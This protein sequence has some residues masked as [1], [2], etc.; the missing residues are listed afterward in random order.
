MRIKRLT[1]GAYHQDST[2]HAFSVYHS[3]SPAPGGVAPDVNF[4]RLQ[5]LDAMF[6]RKDPGYIQSTGKISATF[7]SSPAHIIRDHATGDVYISAA[8]L[9]D[10]A[11]RLGNYLLAEVSSLTR[12]QVKTGVANDM[13]K[14]LDGFQSKQ[15][16][17]EGEQELTT[18]EEAARRNGGE[19]RRRRDNSRSP[20]AEPMDTDV[21]PPQRHDSGESYRSGRSEAGQRS[22]APSASPALSRQRESSSERLELRPHSDVGPGQ[23]P[24]KPALRLQDSNESLHRGST[25]IDTAPVKRNRSD[26]ELSESAQS[27]ATSEALNDDPQGA[28]RPRQ[29]K[30]L[31]INTAVGH[32][33]PGR[34][35]SSALSANP[36]VLEQVRSSLLLKQ[37][38][39][40]IIEARQ[41][42]Q[43]QRNGPMS[44]NP[45][46]SMRPPM[47]AGGPN[48][49][50]FDQRG[51]RRQ[52]SPK[53]KKGKLSVWT[54]EGTSGAG[55]GPN[56]PSVL[57]P[58]AGRSHGSP[59]SSS[60]LSPRHLNPQPG[61][62]T[63]LSA[64]GAGAPTGAEAS[65]YN[66]VS[67]M[68]PRGGEFPSR[69]LPLPTPMHPHHGS[70]AQD[71]DGPP[72]SPLPH[73][74][75]SQKHFS[76]SSL[77]PPPSP[78]SGFPQ[79]SGHPGSNNPPH[80]ALPQSLAISKSAFVSVAE[81]MY[82]QVE[83]TARLQYT[84][85]DQI[86]RSTAM[87]QTL[88]SSGQ[89]IEGLVRGHFREMQVAYGEKFGSALYEL[90]RRV[91]RLERGTAANSR[92]GTVENGYDNDDE[93]GNNK[94]AHRRQ[95]SSSHLLETG[96][97]DHHHHSSSS[98]RHATPAVM[99]T[100]TTT[101]SSPSLPTGPSISHPQQ[102]SRYNSASPRP[103]PVGGDSSTATQAAGGSS[104]GFRGGPPTAV[105][106]NAGN[107]TLPL[108]GETA[109]T[110]GRK[111]GYEG[112]LIQ[113]LMERVEKLEG[114][115][116]E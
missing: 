105:P 53:F 5:D 37:Q 84:L 60:L 98:S 18:D 24:G 38:Q 116:R 111:E 102:R 107:M 29:R 66:P 71:R 83:E 62:S 26:A 82:D 19:G 113:T 43:Y 35:S 94:A 72:R 89:M 70:G 57:H 97:A 36:E 100:I 27:E 4:F 45:D 41:T 8:A 11:K 64:R 42:A 21:K 46:G 80:S 47:S 87:L 78:A 109:A 76:S 7:L 85:R 50:S 67:I 33:L 55:G 22:E 75:H 95:R 23:S 91:E 3:P 9:E 28:G 20:E 16:F 15:P 86:R 93:N 12:D 74:G 65:R 49:G 88:Q 69:E 40:A 10:T 58:P 14:S 1:I 2:V 54:G 92:A 30:R 112:T 73:M 44:A 90:S 56:P 99:P 63:K 110:E 31:S 13:L 32:N 59:S 115:R 25:E 114:K 101:A 68:S 61:K 6:F 34:M 79:Q 96:T 48:A 106:E 108:P 39:Q 103:A 51:N 77:A 81:A 52:S 17:V 104:W